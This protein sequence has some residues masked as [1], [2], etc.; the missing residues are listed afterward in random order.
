MPGTKWV[1]Y[2][3]KYKK[4]WE[5]EKGI[6][7]WIQPFVREDSKALCK[8]CVKYVHTMQTSYNILALKNKTKKKG[9]TIIHNEAYRQSFVIL[10]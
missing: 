6:N 2:G 5:K 4:D 7:E 8:V 9:I 1:K 10:F 3:N